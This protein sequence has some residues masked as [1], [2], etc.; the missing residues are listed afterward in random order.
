MS[1]LEALKAKKEEFDKVR[2]EVKELEDRNRTENERPKFKA[3][4]GTCWKYRNCYSCPVEE[5]DYWWLY[6]MVVGV[7]DDGEID[8]ISMQIDKHGALTI[9]REQ[10]DWT[11]FSDEKH[12]EI[13]AIEWKTMALRAQGVINSLSY[14]HGKS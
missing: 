12:I 11:Y 2:R 5:S 1:L 9:R 14:P 7:A 4:V 10:A 6:K 8:Y 13:N 3:L